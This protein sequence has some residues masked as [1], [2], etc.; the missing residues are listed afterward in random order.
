VTG[1]YADPFVKWDQYRD[2]SDTDLHNLRDVEMRQLQAFVAVGEELHFGRAAARLHMAQSPLS[3]L[4]RR[5]EADVGVPL[6]RRTTRKVELLPA[7]EVLLDRAH[8]IIAAAGA[9][10]E[11][12]RAAAS[13]ELGRLAI[14]FTGS[15]TYALLPHLAKVLRSRLP[16]VRL[17]LRGEML[18]PAQVAGLL[19]GRLDVALLRPP[20]D[21]SELVLETIGVE[22]LVA[23]LPAEHHLAAL[24]RVPV[25]RLADEPFIVYPSSARSVVHDAVAATCADQGFSPIVAMEVAE[26]STLVSFVA[27]GVGVALV[28]ASAR[29]MSVTGAVYRP[30][31]G[32]THLVELAMCWRSASGSPTLPRA[33]AVIRAELEALHGVLPGGV[34]A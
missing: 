3:Q 16:R 9:A 5:L 23:A 34:R 24:E 27:A 6:L 11:D 13:G 14:G 30:L 12:A 17:D 29:Q 26:T 33:L 18:T 7:G 28:P 4:I 1:R 21:H 15:M 8:A 22:P 31:A 10:E 32:A 20:V 25:G 2:D 19:D